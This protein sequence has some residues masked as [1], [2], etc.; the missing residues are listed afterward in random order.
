MKSPEKRKNIEQ[1]KIPNKEISESENEIFEKEIL[2]RLKLYHQT[3]KEKWEKIQEQGALL[4]EKELIK[5]G[6]IKK[7]EK[8]GGYEDTATGDLDREEGRD[9]YVFAVH[10]PQGYG[11]VTLEIDLE[12]LNIEGTKVATAGEWLDYAVEE[13]DKEYFRNSIIKGT[14]FVDYLKKFLKALP[15]KEWFFEEHILSGDTQIKK[16]ILDFMRQALMEKTYQNDKE[17]YRITTSLNPEIMF[18]NELPL[19]YIKNVIINE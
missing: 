17:K 2:E 12:A 13:E 16:E 18:P 14:E 3:T 4:S 6:L 5:R 8:L 10:K 7:D 15:N 1:T 11:E 9:E 19:K